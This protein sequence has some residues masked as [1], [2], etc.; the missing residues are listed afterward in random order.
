MKYKYQG[1]KH[2]YEKKYIQNKDHIFIL[3]RTQYIF[4]C[5]RVVLSWIVV[6]QLQRRIFCIFYTLFCKGYNLRQSLNIKKNR[7]LLLQ[8]ILSLFVS[9]LSTVSESVCVPLHNNKRFLP[10]VYFYN[11]NELQQLLLKTKSFHFFLDSQSVVLLPKT[12]KILYA[13][14]FRYML[15]FINDG[16]NTQTF[17]QF[18]MEHDQAIKV[19]TDKNI[20][21]LARYI[22]QDI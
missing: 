9:Q 20:N 18:C 11:N 15:A 13:C 5:S 17:M 6:L 16:S 2:I 19:K 21:Q 12:T 4:S 8:L 22:K 10:L 3:T 7:W 14:I 1:P